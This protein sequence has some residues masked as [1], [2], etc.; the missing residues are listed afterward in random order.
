MK[1]KTIKKHKNNKNNKNKRTNKRTRKTRITKSKEKTLPDGYRKDLTV[2][3]NPNYQHKFSCFKGE[4]KNLQTDKYNYKKFYKTYES[5]QQIKTLTYLATNY[6]NKILVQLLDLALK[7]FSPALLPNVYKTLMSGMN[8]SEIY[9]E[10]AILY[11]SPLNRITNLS[12]SVCNK[13]KIISEVIYGNDLNKHM[14]SKIVNYL[15]IGCGNGSFTSTFGKQLKLTKDH[16]FGVDF[17][18]F[19]EQGDWG[20][21]KNTSHFTF[22]QL[23]NDKAYPFEDNFFDVITMKMVLHHISNI[24]FTFN[25]IKRILKKNGILIIIDHDAFT[26][27]DYMIADIEHAFYI[28]VFDEN[29]RLEEYSKISKIKNKNIESLDI[30]KY[31]DWL[32]LDNLL[33]KYNFKYMYGQFL[34]DSIKFDVSATRVKYGIYKNL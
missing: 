16:V 4:Y 27:V 34:H 18:N 26:Y 30:V 17:A 1:P 12:P 11:R 22:K 21:G 2:K 31:Y 19:F 10:L 3:I 28:H 23:E 25:E 13:N 15:D 32:E 20:R 24:D 9:S 8:D 7:R 14:P 5:N 29:P 33:M 6:D